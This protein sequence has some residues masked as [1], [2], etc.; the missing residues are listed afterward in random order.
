MRP[1]LPKRLFAARSAALLLVAACNQDRLP[2]SPRQPPAPSP[3]T[4]SAITPA[5]LI[6]AGDI[7][8]C[9]GRKHQTPALGYECRRESLG[10][11][12]GGGRA[13]HHPGDERRQEVLEVL[14]ITSYP[15]AAAAAPDM[16]EFFT[17]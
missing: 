4:Q 17:R 11:R 16:T 10:H 9:D 5:P 3:L 15:G 12:G 1:G 6:G 7:A 8:R 2:T 14:G 13:G